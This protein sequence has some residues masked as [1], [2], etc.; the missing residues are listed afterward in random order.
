MSRRTLPTLVLLLCA[1]PLSAQDLR[2]TVQDLF[3]FGT[4][5]AEPLC[6][7]P[8]VTPG[9]HGR[10]F[11]TALATGSTSLIGFLTDAIGVS[12][13]NV[14]LGATSSGVTF[15]FEGGLPVSTSVSSGPVFGERAQTLGRSRVLI[16]ANVTGVN[17][18]S[19]RGVP[20]NGM[21]FDFAHDNGYAGDVGPNTRGD[22]LFENDV[23][24]VRPNFSVNVTVAS[25]FMTYGLLDHLDIG[26]A[27]PLVRTSV[28]GSSIGRVIPFGNGSPHFFGDTTGG[29]PRRYSDTSFV[30]GSAT[31]IG[32]IAARVK[33]NLH[34]SPRT[35]F[36]VLV[37][38][39]LPTGD[40]KNFLGAGKASVR[41]MGIWSARWSDF[42]PHGN[43]GYLYRGGTRQSNA[44]LTTV[45]FDQLLSPR[46]TL[47]VDFIGEWQVG[48]SKLVIPGAVQI[49]SPIVRLVLPANIPNQHD[50]VVNASIGFKLKAGGLTFVTNGLMPLRKAGLQSD[51]IWTVGAERTF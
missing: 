46:A 28:S 40:E 7:N 34:Q 37:D 29:L 1:A 16:G 48:D 39:R 49:D 8:S 6:L 15:S 5:C 13:S 42:S 45:G 26:V 47:A 9:S 36:A 19:L 20:L 35:G 51:F 17:F 30:D 21:V 10:H 18:Q 27:V 14:P 44:I 43:F 23:F 11:I 31:G 3:Q 4:G 2:S 25:V 33:I 12:V 24:E 41:G 32:D 38:A 50:H 22:P